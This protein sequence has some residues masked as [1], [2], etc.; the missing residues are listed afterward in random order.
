MKIKRLRSIFGVG[1]ATFRTIERR[2]AAHLG[3]VLEA[4]TIGLQL[5]DEDDADGII[6]YFSSFSPAPA[7]A[8]P[9]P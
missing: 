1:E 7:R 9:H 6:D 5:A 4:A 3:D 2:L 8:L